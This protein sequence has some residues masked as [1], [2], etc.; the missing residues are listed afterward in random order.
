MAKQKQEIYDVIIIGA[1]PA[2]L[3][4]AKILDGKKKVVLLEKN[5]IIG[6]KVCAGGLVSHDLAYLKLPDE[7]LDNKFN[8]ITMHTPH[9][10]RQVKLDYNFVNTVD[11]QNLGQW[12]LKKL[13]NIDIRT[14]TRVT[15]I[16]KNYVVANGE[17]I[18]YKYLVGA[19]GSNSIVRKYV[20]LKT[21]RVIMGIQY[22]IP[23]KKYKNLEFFFE[24]KYFNAWYA[25]IFPHKNYVSIGAGCDPKFFSVSKLK[26]NLDVWAKKNNVPIS[27]GEYQAHPINFDYQ[28]YKF[29]NIFLVGDAA[30]LASGMT[31]EGI[32]QALIS[33]EE[34]A[35]VILNNKYIPTKIDELLK[36]RKAHD[37]LLALF[38]K[39]GPLR[40]IEYD[41]LALIL[42]SKLVDKEW[43]K[44]FA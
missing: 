15:E 4:C 18:V 14:K 1:G 27:K 8:E 43:V 41:F 24:S 39:S 21:K 35:K 17:K 34:I 30:G 29:G 10:S 32:Y 42:K 19:D 36:S 7:L 38:E 37:R 3:N 40:E 26:M 2:G 5:E 20:G 9:F 12:Q 16:G 23:T 22:I 31:G 44:K 13:K 6:P 28:G 11:R 33:G 25:W